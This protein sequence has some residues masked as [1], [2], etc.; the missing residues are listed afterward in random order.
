M[1]SAPTITMAI[2]AKQKAAVLPLYL[3]CIANLAYPK[4]CIHLYVRT[5]DNT[6]DTEQLLET[7]LERYGTQ[8]ASV[9]Y[10]KGSCDPALRDIE[11]HD[12]TDRRRFTVLNRIRE[13]SI[14]HA[15]QVGTDF[16]FVADCDNWLLPHT[17]EAL[18]RPGLP[19]VAPL[20]RHQEPTRIYSNFHHKVSPIGWFDPEAPGY[21]EIWGQSRKGFIDVE[22]VHCTYLVRRDVLPLV[23]YE[24]PHYPALGNR[25]DYVVFSEAMRNAQIPQFLDNRDVY[26]WLSLD[27]VVGDIEAWWREGALRRGFQIEE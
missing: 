21:H 6:D 23:Y 10:N 20:L 14:E 25:Y 27:E 19:V 22:C 18:V 16:Y 5:N 2:L 9:V 11:V 26:G 3:K 17:L 15:R 13:S 8:Y 12:W 24:D 4:D 1:A 7:W